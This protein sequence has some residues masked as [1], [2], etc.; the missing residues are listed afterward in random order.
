MPCPEVVRAR[1][2]KACRAR[3]RFRNWVHSIRLWNGF[4]LST[5]PDWMSAEAFAAL[6]EVLR[7]RELRYTVARKGF[8]VKAITLVTTLL[9]PRVYTVE[10]LAEAYG[11]AVDH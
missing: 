2:R 9:D 4:G 3:V 7:V 10:K 1:T 8:R 6:P 11:L 5:R